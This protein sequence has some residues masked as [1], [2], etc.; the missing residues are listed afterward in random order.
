LEDAKLFALEGKK[1]GQSVENE[2][3]KMPL[4]ENLE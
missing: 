2:V 4:K 1:L 3:A